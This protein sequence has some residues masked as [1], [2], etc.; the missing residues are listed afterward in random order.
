[1]IG[2]ELSME[3][4]GLVRHGKGVREIAREVGVS[5][6]TVRRFLRDPA[7]ARAPPRRSLVTSCWKRSTAARPVTS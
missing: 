1:M 3:I 4:R 6:N 7:A 2:V 5:R